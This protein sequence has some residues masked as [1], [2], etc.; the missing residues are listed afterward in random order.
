MRAMQAI[1]RR[2]RYIREQ[3]LELAQ[4][5]AHEALVR[6]ESAGVNYI[7]IYQRSG[8]IDPRAGATRAGGCGIIEALGS[9]VLVCPGRSRGLVRCARLLRK[10]VRAPARPSRRLGGAIQAGRECCS[11]RT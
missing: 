4:P 10:S 11:A 1:V 6:V 8:S 2:S 7:D 9:E 5:S 3:T